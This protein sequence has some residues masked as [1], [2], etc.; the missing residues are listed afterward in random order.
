M[1]P[2]LDSATAESLPLPHSISRLLG[3]SD[4]S[5][6]LC[7]E[8]K[9]DL[10]QRPQ[11][12]P[13]GLELVLLSHVN[14]KKQAAKKSPLATGLKS[15]G[16]PCWEHSLECCRWVGLICHRKCQHFPP[17][18]CHREC[19]SHLSPSRRFL[20]WVPIMQDR[21]GPTLPWGTTGSA[22]APIQRSILYG[23]PYTFMNF[24]AS[25]GLPSTSDNSSTVWGWESPQNPLQAL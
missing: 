12:I 20:N 11:Q 21:R 23:V 5:S 6:A 25:S 3:C 14:L 18:K 16:E 4:L 8:S 1:W 9:S 2:D 7:P 13:H 10:R 17:K 15:R 19:I 24:L 22:T